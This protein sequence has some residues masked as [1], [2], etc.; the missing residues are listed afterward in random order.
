MITYY[1]FM[2]L[3]QV[4]IDN[5]LLET[6]WG[7]FFVLRPRLKEPSDRTCHKTYLCVR[8]MLV[9]KLS[10]LSTFYRRVKHHL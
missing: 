1:S 9:N 6:G 7:G 8:A 3:P 2:L 4:L 10:P 5:S